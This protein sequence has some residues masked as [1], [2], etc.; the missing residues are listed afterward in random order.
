MKIISTERIVAELIDLSEVARSIYDAN[1]SPVAPIWDATVENVR[2]FVMRQAKA[3]AEEMV[4]QI[5][6]D[7]GRDR[8]A[9]P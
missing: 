6:A 8:G 9:T 7:D 3:A 2:A 5:M 1:R 4:R